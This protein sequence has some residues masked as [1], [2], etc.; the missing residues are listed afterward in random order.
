MFRDGEALMNAVLNFEQSREVVNT[1]SFVREPHRNASP[2]YSQNAESRR[3][4]S[5]NPGKMKYART[6]LTILI[7]MPYLP[8][9][10]FPNFE[11]SLRNK[12]MYI[13]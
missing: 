1:P 2:S 6:F 5:Q 4:R 3:S 8:G 13:K 12:S 11:Q 7:H 10:Y 9:Y